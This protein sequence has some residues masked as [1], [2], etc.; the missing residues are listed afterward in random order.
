M[1]TAA[2]VGFGDTGSTRS[3]INALAN[4]DLP[5]LNAPNSAIVKRLPEAGPL[6]PHRPNGGQAKSA[7]RAALRRSAASAARRCGANAPACKADLGADTD[8]SPSAAELG[9]PLFVCLP[10]IAAADAD[11]TSCGTALPAAALSPVGASCSY[12]LPRQPPRQGSGCGAHCS[13]PGARLRLGPAA[14][15]LCACRRGCAPLCRACALRAAPLPTCRG[16]GSCGRCGAGGS[17]AASRAK[18]A[19]ARACQRGQLQQRL[20]L[21]A[22]LAQGARAQ[23]RQQLRQPLLHDLQASRPR[24]RPLAVDR[25]HC[26]S[27][28]SAVLHRIFAS[29]YRSRFNLLDQPFLQALALK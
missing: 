1:L 22:Q 7:A 17:S 3:P 2:V 28:L 16:S 18:C 25:L 12:V 13:P 23:V 15:P 6:C 29:E 20:R 5:A 24:H 11:S 8:S 19:A 27:K 9:Q 4:D 14:S 21:R 10:A 26:R